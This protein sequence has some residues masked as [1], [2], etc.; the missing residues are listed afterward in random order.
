MI[1]TTTPTIEGRTVARYLGVATGEVIVGANVLRDMFASLTDILGG[2][3]SA[4]EGSIRKA[5]QQALEE[6]AEE[7]RDL[8]ADAV[9]AVSITYGALGQGD[10][11]FM[12]TATGTAVKLG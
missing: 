2:R 3:A 12:V 4:Y 6:L 9:L 1:L 11:M 5:R 7:A 8:G 10:S